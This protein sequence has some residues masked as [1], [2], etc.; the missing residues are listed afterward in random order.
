MDKKRDIS[1][2]AK[3]TGYRFKGSH[4]K[5]G[6]K[7][8]QRPQ[9]VLSASEFREEKHKG[10]IAYEPRNT[11]GDIHPR[12]Y[13]EYGGEVGSIFAKIKNWLNSPIK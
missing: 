3:P 4:K 7:Y 12:S 9:N 1:R 6:S 11:K 2:K 8:Y 10:L 5:L 13:Y